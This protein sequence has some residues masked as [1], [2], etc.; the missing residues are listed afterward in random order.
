MQSLPRLQ[1]RYRIT[2]KSIAVRKLQLQKKLHGVLR[3]GT[4][5]LHLKVS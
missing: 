5:A 1:L 2:A 4:W 3:C